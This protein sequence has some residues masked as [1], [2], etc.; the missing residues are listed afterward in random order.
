MLRT[1][2]RRH[3]HVR[4]L[5]VLLAAAVAIAAA[6][7]TAVYLP[8][9][10]SDKEENKRLLGELPQFPNSE[11][12]EITAYPYHDCAWPIRRR[13]GYNTSARYRVPPGATA[14]QVVAFYMESLG[15]EWL[16]TREDIGIASPGFPGQ[17]SGQML[18]SIPAARFTKGTAT[19]HVSTDNMVVFG[20][21]APNREPTYNFTV[22]VDSEGT[23]ERPYCD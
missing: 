8:L 13:L 18:G 23:V 6:A 20:L 22:S 9:G 19:V 15:G 21:A 1:Q 3:L 7:I 5:A 10:S 11:I 14:E 4:R 2:F 17:P 12:V 16:A